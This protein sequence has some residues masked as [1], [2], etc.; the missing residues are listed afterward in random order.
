MSKQTLPESTK[1]AKEAPARNAQPARPARGRPYRRQTARVEE[2]RDGKPLLFGW[3]KHLSRRQKNKIQS[4]A[5]WSFVVVAIIAV[6]GVLGYAYYNIN[7][8]IP[9]QPI[10][11]VNGHVIPQSLFRKLNFYL[12]QDLTN[13]QAALSQ[14]Q[15]AA[16]KLANSTDPTKQ[17]QGQQE[18]SAIQQQQ[19]VLQAQY[20]IPTVGST[21]VEDLVDDELIQEQIPILEAHGVPASTLEASEK[22]ITA[23][24][25]AFKKAFPSTVTYSQFLSASKMTEDDVRQLVAILVRHDKMDAYQQ[26]LVHPTMPQVHASLIETTT[27]QDAAKILSQL[28]GLSATDLPTTFAKLAKRDSKDANSKSKGGDLGWIVYG[29]TATESAAERWLFASSRKV[30]DLSP[31][32]DV[33]GGVYKIFYISALDQH[34]PVS[35]DK[36]TTLKSEALTEWATLLRSAP[37]TTITDTDSTKLLDPNNFP[38]NLPSG[39]S[40]GTGSGTNPVGP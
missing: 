8:G 5:F 6:V 31:A 37:N 12:A 22:D 27:K 39:A 4:R 30:G 21:S 7:Y 34:R 32:I 11:T 26:S 18:L 17:Q 33:S 1:N 13:Q 15:T 19:Q 38:A 16:Q 40:S 28:Q 23:R 3:G 29:D 24:L 35:A 9:G 25:N 2:R 20:S 36:L 10:V 14:Q